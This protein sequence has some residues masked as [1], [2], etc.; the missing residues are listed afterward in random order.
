MGDGVLQRQGTEKGPRDCPGL[1]LSSAPP[2]PLLRA[3]PGPAQPQPRSSQRNSRVPWRNQEQPHGSL[4]LT[5][6]L[7]PCGHGA[8]A[9]GLALR[10]IL[11]VSPPRTAAHRARARFPCCPAA[12]SSRSAAPDL[13][14]SPRRDFGPKDEVTW[15]QVFRAPPV[16]VHWAPRLSYHLAFQRAWGLSGLAVAW[17]VSG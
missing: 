15:V 6:R 13:V 17:E 1:G 7:G 5:D 8:A 11:A 10:G 14:V 2:P 9:S 4:E 16:W 3:G 12:L